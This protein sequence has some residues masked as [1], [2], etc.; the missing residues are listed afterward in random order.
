MGPQTYQEWRKFSNWEPFTLAASR[1]PGEIFWAHSNPQEMVWPK[2]KSTDLGVAW[3]WQKQAPSLWASYSSFAK[4]KVG[5]GWTK[6]PRW[7]LPNLWVTVSQLCIRVRA[8]TSVP[9]SASP[10][11]AARCSGPQP[12]EEPL[13][14]QIVFGGGPAK[15]GKPENLGGP[16]P[17]GHSVQ[18]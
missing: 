12:Q 9:F 15:G 8:V 17:Q 10:A 11:L 7:A 6:E 16:C 5:E 18:A 3:P 13:P 4:V 14:P 1:Q 2:V